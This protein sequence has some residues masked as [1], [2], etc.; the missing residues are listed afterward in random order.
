LAFY[1]EKKDMLFTNGLG[2]TY[3][4][5]TFEWVIV[6]RFSSYRIQT[7]QPDQHH[8]KPPDNHRINSTYRSLHGLHEQRKQNVSHGE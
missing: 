2:A 4:Q 8:Q 6:A 7:L 5:A 3:D 1:D